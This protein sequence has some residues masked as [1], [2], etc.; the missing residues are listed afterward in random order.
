MLIPKLEINHYLPVARYSTAWAAS[1]VLLKRLVLPIHVPT[2]L[3]A[4]VCKCQL[5]VEVACGI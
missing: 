1:G 2:S 3:P 5:V 4:N